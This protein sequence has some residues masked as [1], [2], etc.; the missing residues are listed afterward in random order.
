MFPEILNQ[1]ITTTTITAMNIDPKIIWGIFGLALV[2]AVIMS[3]VLLYHWAHYSYRP[4]RTGAMGAL[5]FS[6]V[7]VLLGVMF[8]ATTTYIGSL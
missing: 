5:Y 7:V 1:S 2:S 4:I 8:F 6:G 3:T